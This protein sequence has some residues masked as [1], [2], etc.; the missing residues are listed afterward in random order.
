VTLFDFLSLKNNVN[1]PSKSN[2][3]NKLC[4]KFFAVK[5]NDKNCRIQ[6]HDPDPD[7]LVRGTDPGIRIRARM[8]RIRNTAGFQTGSDTQPCLEQ[9]KN[10]GFGPDC[11]LASAA[12]GESITTH[13][14]TGTEVQVT[15]TG[16]FVPIFNPRS[17]ELSHCRISLTS[18]ADSGCL[19]RIPDP[20][21]K[22]APDPGSQ[23][24]IGNTG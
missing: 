24:R 3:Q 16:N 2:K 14:I 10:T 4:K 18:V 19:S 23:I 13:E 17:S 7:P 22:K 6:I 9:I 20:G 5:V 12:T 8:S 11:E 1:V 21:F 15:G